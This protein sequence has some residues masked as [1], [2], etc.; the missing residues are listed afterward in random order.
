MSINSRR[1]NTS[2]KLWSSGATAKDRWVKQPAK[3]SVVPTSL[4]YL[5]ISRTDWTY[6]IQYRNILELRVFR[7]VRKFTKSNYLLRHVCPSVRLS[8]RNNTA[9]TGRIIIKF[10]ISIFF[11]NMS[12]KFKLHSNLACRESTLHEKKYTFLI[13]SLSILLRMRNV[14]HRKSK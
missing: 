4:W 3:Y 11:E 6:F 2:F 14:S 5:P 13:T 12:I 7:R 10:D 1:R 8:A 9:P